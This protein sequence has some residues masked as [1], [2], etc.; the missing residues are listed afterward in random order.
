MDTL[1]DQQKI[2]VTYTDKPLLVLAGAGSG[3]TKVLTHR[4]VYLIEKGLTKAENCL[5][6]TFTNKAAQEMK[7]RMGGIN[8]G[9]AGTFHGFC[10]KVL[11]ID[12]NHI[13]VPQNFIIYDAIDQKDAVKQILESMNLSTDKFNPNSILNGIGDIKNQMLT[14][15]EYKGYARGE[16]Q[17]VIAKVYEALELC[18][19]RV[20]RLVERPLGVNE[21]PTW[22]VLLEE[23]WDVGEDLGRLQLQLVEREVL[24]FRLGPRVLRTPELV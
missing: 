3:K 22:E 12:G 17:E 13:G 23:L 24:L 6:L 21:P 8:L 15:V 5:L 1:N 10:A 14:P 19:L 11:R 20:D 9:Y 16:W 2:A 4:V 7:E 18:A